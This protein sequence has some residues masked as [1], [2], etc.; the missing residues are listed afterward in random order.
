[1]AQI[2]NGTALHCYRAIDRIK[3]KMP[4]STRR[5]MTRNDKF[6]TSYLEDRCPQCGYQKGKSSK[7]AYN[8]LE[9]YVET[10]GEDL[11]SDEEGS[12]MTMSTDLETPGGGES[13]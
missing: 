4:S 3:Q 11:Y 9:V 8:L 2:S 12:T 5:L 6:L 7:Q 13:L 1:M 10:G